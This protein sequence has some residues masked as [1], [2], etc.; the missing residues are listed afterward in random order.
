MSGGSAPPSACGSSEPAASR[1]QAPCRRASAKLGGAGDLDRSLPE[2]DFVVVC[3]HLTPETTR[4]FNNDRFAAMK[5][6]GRARQ[7]RPGRDRRQ[8]GPSRTRSSATICV[9]PLS[10][11]MSA[12]SSTAAWARLWS[13]PP[14]ADHAAYLLSDQERHG[15]ID[16]FCTIFAPTPM[17]AAPKCHRLGTGLLKLGA[18]EEISCLCRR[19]HLSA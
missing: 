14:G 7:R 18:R 3:C 15:A 8:G 2:S 11:F 5:R 17:A 1:R 6:G 13:R 9:A 10:M 16:L 19:R 4:L 12:S